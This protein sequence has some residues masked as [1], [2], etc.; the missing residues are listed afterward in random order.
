MFVILVSEATAS[1]SKRQQAERPRLGLRWVFAGSKIY[2]ITR[3]GLE[4]VHE[5]D[6]QRRTV[7]KVQHRG[8]LVL[9][10]HGAVIVVFD[11]RRERVPVA[12][13]F[14]HCTVVAVAK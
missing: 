13:C 4:V 12:D 5:H 9:V 10:V 1:D 11:V 6:L 3:F 14:L 2:Q 7:D 8:S